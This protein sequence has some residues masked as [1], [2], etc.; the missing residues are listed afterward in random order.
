MK[1]FILATILAL[2]A[3]NGLHAKEHT[4][5]RGETLES[6][7]SMY[8]VNEQA[9]LEANPGLSDM[10]FTGLVITIPE[11]LEDSSSI[12]PHQDNPSNTIQYSESHPENGQ[13][14]SLSDSSRPPLI[15]PD[16]NQNTNTPSPTGNFTNFFVT[17]LG[18]VKASFKGF[19]GFGWR[20]FFDDGFALEMKLLSNFGFDM[21]DAITYTIGPGYGYAVSDAFMAH[22]FFNGFLNIYTA[23]GFPVSGGIWAT[24]GFSFKIGDLHLGISYNLGFESAK[25]NT[26]FSHFLQ[27]NVGF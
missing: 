6:I 25:G 3:T 27:L 20:K 10:F 14:Y 23:S 7:A 21:G 16:N 22:I 15:F 9:I 1:H 24:P 12:Q 2:L 11:T 26:I 17:Y 8:Q 5:E 4:I 19:Y 18:H 13:P